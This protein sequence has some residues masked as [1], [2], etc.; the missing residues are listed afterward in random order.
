[1]EQI[2]YQDLKRWKYRLRRDYKVH[3]GFFETKAERGND[4]VW[5]DHGLLTISKGYAWDGPSGP[6]FDTRNWMR[7]SLVHD[8]LY[9][10]IREKHVP[11]DLRKKVD[12]L[13]RAQLLE[14]GMSRARAGWSYAGA[15]LFGAPAAKPRDEDRILKAP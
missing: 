13:M 14:D 12:Q 7:A 5:L 2:W 15:R 9:Q 11:Q 8:A 6:T 1:M 4:F 3:I 10:L